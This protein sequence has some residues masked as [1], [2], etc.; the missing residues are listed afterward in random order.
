MR[1]LNDDELEELYAVSFD[2]H[3]APA[4]RKAADDLL[5]SGCTGCST[6]LPELQRLLA[7]LEGARNPF[8]ALF[9]GPCCVMLACRSAT[10]SRAAGS[11]VHTRPLE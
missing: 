11:T 10:L 8:A 5:R 4:L 6:V 7:P 9:K 2:Q 1:D 3:D